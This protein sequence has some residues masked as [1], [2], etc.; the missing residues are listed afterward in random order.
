MPYGLLSI[1]LGI[2]IILL[3][4]KL[5]KRD[6]NLWDKSTTFKGVVAGFLLIIFGLSMIFRV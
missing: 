3:A 5:S 1:L 2:I 4:Y 6:K